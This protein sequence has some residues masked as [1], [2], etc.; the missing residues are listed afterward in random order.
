MIERKRGMK[1][2]TEM[3]KLRDRER[4]TD[5]RKKGH[6]KRLRDGEK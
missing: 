3:E 1:E 2:D 6:K 4:E 5:W